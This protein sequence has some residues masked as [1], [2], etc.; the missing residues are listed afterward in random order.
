[1]AVLLGHIDRLTGRVAWMLA[2]KRDLGQ[3]T[4]LFWAACLQPGRGKSV[5]IACLARPVALR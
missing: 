5:K 1:V 4:Q 3:A 2:D